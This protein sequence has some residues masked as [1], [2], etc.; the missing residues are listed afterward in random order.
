MNVDY[1]S[2]TLPKTDLAELYRGL[3]LRHLVE[4]E[5]RRE[6][7]LEEAGEPKVLIALESALN[8]TD[9]EADAL[10]HRAEDELWDYA[11]YAYTDEWAW[12]RARQEVLEELGTK[13]TGLTQEALDRKTEDRYREKF[14]AYVAEIDMREPAASTKKKKEKKRAQK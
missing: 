7:G 4:N 14:D 1:A 2:I 8:L 5:I 3:V 9:T 10:Y 11:W 6:E 13:R 12:F